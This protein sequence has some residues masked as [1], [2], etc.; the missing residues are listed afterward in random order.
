MKEIASTS[1]EKAEVAFCTEVVGIESHSRQ[2]NLPSSVLVELKDGTKKAF[3]EVV[4]TSPLGWLKRNKSAFK[5]PLSTSLSSAIDNINY[6]RLEKVYIQFPRAYWGKDRF[7]THFLPPEYVSQP[8][9]AGEWNQECVNL[10]ALDPSCAHPTLLYYIYG[11]CATHVTT[12]IKGLKTGSEEYIKTLD[13]FFRPYYSKLPM[14]DP[15]SSDCRPTGILATNWQADDLAGNGSYSNFQIGLENGDAD[16]ERMREGCGEERGV[17]LA[18][19]HTAPF[20]ALGTTTGAYWSG[21]GVARRIC[22]LYRLSDTKS[23]EENLKKVPNKEKG[24][25]PSDAA[26]AH[27]LGL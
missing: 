25:V 10:A 19:E 3:D 12:I 26:Q 21:E 9:E 17:W 27:G 16:I 2:Q 5:P 4:V 8:P 15:A 14:F 11:P 23:F 7:F 6:G 18:G 1:L 13:N 22:S 24:T 20:V